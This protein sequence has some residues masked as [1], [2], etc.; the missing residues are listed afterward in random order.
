MAALDIS[1]AFGKVNHFLDRGVPTCLVKVLVC[2]YG[3][4]NAVVRWNE[5]IS[6]VFCWCSSRRYWYSVS[7]IICRV[8]LLTAEYTTDS[9]HSYF[10]PAWYHIVDIRLPLIESTVVSAQRDFTLVLYTVVLYTISCM[11]YTQKLLYKVV[12]Y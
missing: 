11:V 4:C 10:T 1:K 7:T 9:L 6:R 12:C 5:R 2:W 8:Y 3:K